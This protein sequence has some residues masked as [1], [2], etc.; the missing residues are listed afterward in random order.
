MIISL[1]C[2][3]LLCFTALQESPNRFRGLRSAGLKQITNLLE[4]WSAAA[5]EHFAMADISF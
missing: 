5:L 3:E 1:Y 4:I 2:N